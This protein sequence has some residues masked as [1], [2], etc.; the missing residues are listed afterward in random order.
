M[1]AAPWAWTAWGCS[2]E[3]Q[4][5]ECGAAPSGP[6]YCPNGVTADRCACPLYQLCPGWCEPDGGGFDDL[7]PC[8]GGGDGG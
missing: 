1:V 2:S 7:V 8:S 3:A 5:C 6:G 4:V